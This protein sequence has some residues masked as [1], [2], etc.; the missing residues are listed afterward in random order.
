M[1]CIHIKGVDISRFTLGTV[2]LGMNYGM[3]NAGGKPSQEQAF[4]VL[5]AAHKAGVNSLDTASDYGTSEQ[6]LGDWQKANGG[7]MLITSKFSLHSDDPVA[8]LKKEIA[9]SRQRLGHLDG[10]LFHS[11]SHMQA[12]A[13]KVRDVL[14]EMKETGNMA[15]IGASVYTADEVEDFLEKFPWLEAIQIPM[16]VLDTRIVQRGLLDE[17][18]R[19]GVVVFV[20]SVFLQ[21]M[22]CMEKAPEKYAFMQPSLNE[23]SEV[24][25]AGGLTLPQLAV[26]YIRDLPGVTSL[27]LGCEKPE[28]VLEN[29]DMINGRPLTAA[30]LD[31]ITE[32]SRRAPIEHCMNVIQGK[33]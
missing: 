32:I 4:A 25:K 17:L 9:N 14:E 10:Y 15:F 6:I 19:R 7:P 22:L 16:N 30:E 27:V 28:Q 12:H 11:A 5:D 31:A 21:G 20:R 23:I 18:K 3:A 29:A 24:A 1:D 13:D 26:S 8:E 2:Q 33:A